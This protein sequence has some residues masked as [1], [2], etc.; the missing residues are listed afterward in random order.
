MTSPG[1]RRT[2]IAVAG[3]LAGVFALGGVLLLWNDRETVGDG[4]KTVEGMVAEQDKVIDQLSADS[5]EL[6]QQLKQ[7]GIKPS[8]PPPEE[9]TDTLDDLPDVTLIPGPQ[10][11][12]GP[13][14]PPGPQGD[15]GEDGLPGLAGPQGLPG[16]VGPAGAT[17]DPGPIGPQGEPGPVGPAGADGLDGADGADGRGLVSIDCID[18]V[19]V[20]TYDAAPFTQTIDGTTCQFPPGRGGKE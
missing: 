17:G 10:G 15:T 19:L 6:R 18:G 12:T 5:K 1:R 4:L 16:D 13:P 11:D 3:S 7:R 8:A 9:R 14:G 20:A 2:V